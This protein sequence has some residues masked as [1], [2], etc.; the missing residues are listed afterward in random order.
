MKNTLDK[1]KHLFIAVRL[2]SSRLNK[3]ALKILYGKPL[4]ERLV[5]R[6]LKKFKRSDIVICTSTNKEDDPLEKFAIEKTNVFRGH[7]LDVIKRFLDATIIYKS[8][9]IA[10]ITGDNP[11]TDPDMLNYM[12][13]QHYKN[14]S[15]YTF[16]NDIPIGTRAE[17]ID[18]RALKRIHKQLY[19]PNQSEYMT[20]MLRRPD[21]LNILELESPNLKCKRPEVSLTVDTEK[22]Y[23]CLNY[24]YNHYKGNPPSLEK[25]INLLDKNPNL[26]IINYS[27]FLE[28][29]THKCK[30]EYSYK[31][32]N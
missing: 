21:K 13:E 1:K 23:Q 2:K 24:I 14:K 17:I 22:D 10:R 6:L 27:A 15:E 30:K 16:T 26:K 12:F 28:Y 8:E 19:D 9:T 3:K 4:I 29:N 25:I 5:E 31:D 20:Y 32:D 11:L 18:V 7:E